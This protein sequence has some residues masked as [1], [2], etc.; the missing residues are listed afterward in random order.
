MA[1]VLWGRAPEKFVAPLWRSRFLFLGLVASSLNLVVF[2]V[3]VT[4]LRLHHTDHFWWQ[5]HDRFEFISDCLI[6]FAILAAVLGKGRGRIA[7]GCAAV[8]A[9][10][11]WVVGH[12]GIL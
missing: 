11:I 10:F 3:Y 2:W 5:V 12:I 9:Y 6:G 4:W 8:T 7:M 1:W